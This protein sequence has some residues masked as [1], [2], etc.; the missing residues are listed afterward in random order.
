ML[1][2]VV[3]DLPCSA[4]NA[5]MGYL[6]WYFFLGIVPLQVVL[7]SHRLRSVIK[8]HEGPAAPQKALLVR[9]QNASV[10]S[11]VPTPHTMT[12]VQVLT[13]A[14]KSPG[15]VSN[16]FAVN[17]GAGD[18]LCMVPGACYSE[19]QEQGHAD[20]VYPLFRH[21]GFSGIAVEGNP[22]LM[23]LLTKNLPEQ[24]VSKVSSWITP[25]TSMGLMQSAATPAD[26]DYFKND[27]DAYDC[28]VLYSVLRGGY[29][30][31]VIQV[32]VNPE[33]PY[34]IAFGINYATEFKSNLGNA[35]FYGC[36]LTLAAGVTQP[37]GYALVAVAQTHDVI[38]VRKDLLPGSDLKELT[39]MEA[40]DEQAKCCLNPNGVGH[41]AHLSNYNL[42]NAHR[43]NPDFMLQ[44]MQPAVKQACSISQG[45]PND[46]KIPY[47]LSLKVSDF[48]DQYNQVMMKI[49]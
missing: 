26:L 9:K 24:N 48:L 37:F 17:F 41:F 39:V 47:T 12:S 18:G 40:Q 33:I 20:P 3:S 8:P 16:R 5:N 15:A 43:D 45:T 23:P 19:E 21:L 4:G 34:P 13:A 14:L 46:C 1:R 22:M 42:L 38:F 6:C 11:G 35:G 27:I 36:S 44:A 31:K 49:R 2:Q 10:G 32:E 29:R 7:C 30:P 25:L 28:S